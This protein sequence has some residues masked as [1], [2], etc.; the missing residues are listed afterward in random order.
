MT[1]RRRGAPGQAVVEFALVATALFMLFVA[2]FEF[3]RLM[4]YWIAMQQGAQEAARVG[5]VATDTQAQIVQVA[6]NQTALLGPGLADCSGNAI[7]AAACTSPTG[8]AIQVSC[9]QDT[10]G[11]ATSGCPR[12]SDD[13]LRVVITYPFQ[14]VPLVYPFGTIRLQSWAQVRVE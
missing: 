12:V 8:G 11:D 7:T 2:V 13:W 6:R 1:R 3:G 5:A 10:N 14:P 4:A 9:T